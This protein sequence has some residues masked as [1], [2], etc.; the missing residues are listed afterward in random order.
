M[1]EGTG[2]GE[3]TPPFFCSGKVGRQAGMEAP[4]FL[5]WGR[6]LAR[7]EE[8]GMKP[9][10]FVAVCGR[11]PARGEEGRKTPLFLKKGVG[12]ISSGAWG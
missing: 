11:G 5:Q 7:G 1:E 12:F 9:P 4:L 10:L 6:G 2:K 3:G 8:G